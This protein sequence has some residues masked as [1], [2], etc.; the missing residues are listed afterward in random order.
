MWKTWP[1]G[2]QVRSSDGVRSSRQVGH[3]ALISTLSLR[4]SEDER[5]G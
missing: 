2:V 3:L 5:Q 4:I 1:Q